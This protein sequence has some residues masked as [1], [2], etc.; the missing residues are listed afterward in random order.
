[1]PKNLLAMLGL[2]HPNTLPVLLKKISHLCGLLRRSK[3]EYEQVATALSDEE[4]CP[5]ILTLAQESNQYACELSAQLQVLSGGKIAEEKTQP[6]EADLTRL[7]N[8]GA[9]RRFCKRREKEIVSAYRKLLRKSYLHEGLRQM[10]HYQLEGMRSAFVQL[11]L[12]NSLKF[13]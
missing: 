9:L 8:A 6:R 13:R 3:K 4:L 10:I 2:L 1:M 12:L 5:A 7:R 11:E